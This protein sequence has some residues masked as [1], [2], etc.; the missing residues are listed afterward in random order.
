MWYGERTAM[1]KPAQLEQEWFLECRIGLWAV[2]CPGYIL[3]PRGSSM[4]VR[5]GE[6]SLQIFL[7]SFMIKGVNLFSRW[8]LRDHSIQPSSLGR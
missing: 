1:S 6:A 7:S 4:W 5:R 8:G 2:G 3:S